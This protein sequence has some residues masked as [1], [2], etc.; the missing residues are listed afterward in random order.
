MN[1]K[2]I[3]VVM[4]SAMLLVLTAC[5]QTVEEQVLTGIDNAEM[6]FNSDQTK[7]NKS[8]GHIELYLPKG[9]GIEK[10]IDESN[11]TIVNGKDAYILFVNPNETED[12]QLHYDILKED[13]NSEILQDK[14]FKADDVFGFAAVVKRSE[15]K[16]EIVVSVGGVKMST[17]SGDKK[18]D[19]KIQE[20]MEMVRSVK[21]IH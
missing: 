9:Y 15:E 2:W 5:G 10:G 7:S 14:T 21:V 6:V 8:I 4:L 12:S 18:L 13:P 11:Y 16:Y 1:R 3:Q 17:I 20:M 19:A